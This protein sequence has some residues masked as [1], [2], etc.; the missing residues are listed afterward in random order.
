M[1]ERWKK[2]IGGY[3]E[4]SSYGNVRS[5]KRWKRMRYPLGMLAQHTMKSGY[6]VVHARG[7]SF[8]VHVLV[9]AAFLGPCPPGKEVN[10]QDLDKSN[11]RWDNLEYVT[12]GR[13][14]RHALAHGVQ[15]G[16]EHAP[17]GDSSPN[18]KLT[19]RQREVVMRIYNRDVRGKFA[20]NRG[21]WTLRGIAERFGVSQALIEKVVYS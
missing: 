7:V 18:T 9:A 19:Q 4:V 15:F 3:C 20:N 2:C 21:G 5:I 16:L 12:H 10:H 1:P 8:L 17:R 6:R 14:I 13:N 11:N